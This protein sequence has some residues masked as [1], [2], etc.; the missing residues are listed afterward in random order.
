MATTVL[1][2]GVSRYLGGR[3][4]APADRRARRRPGHRRRRH[5]AAARHRRGRV[6]PR[7]HPQP[8]DRQDHR[9]GR[10]RHGRAHERHRHAGVGRRAGLPEGDQRHRHDAAAGRLP[11]G[12]GHPAAG[13]QVLRRGLRLLAARPRDVHRGHGPQGAA[14]GR[15]RQGLGRGRGLRPRVLPPPARRRD[16]DAAAGQR[17]RP[18]H[19]DRADRLLQPARS[20]RCRSATTPGCSSCTRTTRCRRCCWRPPARRSASSTSPGTA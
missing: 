19:Q 8:D 15:V 3:F 13:R 2:T 5:P 17:H 12:S 14:A 4:A 11:E 1:V 18:G 20:S 16:L 10:G 7:R 9:P 6:R